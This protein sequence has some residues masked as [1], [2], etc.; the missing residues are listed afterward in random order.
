M[1]TQRRSTPAELGD[2]PEELDTVEEVSND[3]AL[4]LLAEVEEIET[5]TVSL[6]GMDIEFPL[7]PHWSVQVI[8]DFTAGRVMEAFAGMDFSSD[9]L[10]A[11]GRINGKQLVTLVEH[12]NKISGDSL[13]EARGS[14]RSSRSTG[15]KS[16]RT[17]ARSIKSTSATTGGRASGRAS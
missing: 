2:E 11:L 1:A 7:A 12:L 3:F 9:E 6:P 8:S 4:D 14:A 13:G 5:F 10:A 17:S 15:T 16:K